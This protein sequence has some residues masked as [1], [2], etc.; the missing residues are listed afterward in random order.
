MGGLPSSSTGK[1]TQ[2][3]WLRTV[4]G[5]LVTGAAFWFLTV[6]LIRDWHRIPFGQ[7]HFQP[8]LL[9][10]SFVLLLVFHLPLYGYAWKLILHA[11]GA[12]LPL[13][14]S[15]AIFSVAQ[16]GKYAPGKVWFTLGRMSMAKDQGVPEDRTMVSVVVELA[17]SLLAATGLF[18]LAVLLIPGEQMPRAAYLLFLLAPLSLVAVYPPILNRIIRFGLARL[19]RPLFEL[20]MSYPRILRILALYVLDWALQGACCFALINSF[21]PMPL[22]KLPILLGGYAMSWMLGFLVL[23]APAGLGIREGVYTIILR[24]VLPEPIAIVSALV[25][26]VWMTVSEVLMAA[27]CLPFVARRRKN[28]EEAHTASS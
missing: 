15:I 8:L 7:L 19:K 24:T 28:A 11:L 16:I 22:S 4:L 10:A 18:G 9:V 27:V 23:I 3:G 5:V 20:R 13:G 17:F 25:T 1:W 6:R 14:K 12:E 26:R 21:Y 2:R